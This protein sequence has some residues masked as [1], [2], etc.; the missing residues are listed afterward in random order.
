MRFI[1]II[2]WR[3]QRHR[4]TFTRLHSGEKQ[5]AERGAVYSSVIAARNKKLPH[6]L[7]WHSRLYMGSKE[8]NPQS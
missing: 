2:E 4:P 6:T 7:L 5:Q 8:A 1:V 3:E